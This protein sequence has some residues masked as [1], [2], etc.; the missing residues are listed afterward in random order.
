MARSKPIG[1]IHV[2]LGA[3]D[4]TT[5]NQNKQMQTDT[6][7][8]VKY[9]EDD[10]QF[11]YLLQLSLQSPTH[12]SIINALDRMVYGQ[13]LN[14]P[15]AISP[16]ELRKIVGD[17]NRFGNWTGQKAGG[18]PFHISTNYIRAKEVDDNGNI[19]AFGYSTDW[20]DAR[21]EVEELDNWKVKPNAKT[22]VYYGR[23]Y[24]P[25][26][27]YYAPATFNAG[28]RYMEQEI[29]I[30]KYQLNH[31]KNGFSATKLINHNNGVPDEESR[32][33]IV[34]L[35][36]NKL[37]GGNGDPIIFA[38]ND[39][40]ERATTIENIDIDNAVDKYTYASEEAARQIMKVNGISSP[41]ILGLP[42]ANGFSSNAEELREAKIRFIND[43][44]KP[45]QDF[46]A[47]GLNE[48][49]GRTDL[50]FLNETAAEGEEIIEDETE[51]VEEELSAV[52]EDLEH[53]ISLGDDSLEG[54]ELFS[55]T[56]VNY[57]LED[58]LD[59]ILADHFKPKTMLSKLVSLVSTG[60]ARPNSKSTQDSEDFVVRYRYTRGGKSNQE[61]NSDRAFCVSMDRANKLYRKEDIT[62]LSKRAVNPGFGV[63]GANTYDIWLYKGGAR[64]RHKWFREVYLKAGTSVDVRN[65]LAKKISVAEAKRRGGKIQ[66]NDPKVAIVPDNMKH[67][68]F[69][70]KATMPKDAKA[71][72]KGI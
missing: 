48:W 63:K 28:M 67:K 11:N 53:F 66:T 30:A 8:Y 41:V 56:E 60:T 35:E 6:N 31:S 3:N 39:D 51:I 42:T 69:V 17:F 61:P 45:I 38:F 13:G 7:G 64:C 25:N 44:V 14:D 22:S 34:R 9:G 37:T 71:Q 57:D 47:Q 15:T 19:P 49:L 1:A 24:V 12:S 55:S 2:E 36:K 70:T 27:F 62:Q 10:D 5:T 54:F 18:T 43:K 72:T 65:P 20:Q 33:K 29:E 21:I 68:A 40:K 58:E 23:P 50:E 59:T 26:A 4:P 32:K 52:N 46:I 16:L